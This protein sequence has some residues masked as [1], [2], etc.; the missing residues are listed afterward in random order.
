MV[1]RNNI[2]KLTNELYS[3]YKNVFVHKIQD[4]NDIKYALKP[5]VYGIH[6]Q[7][8]ETKKSTTWTDCKQYIYHLPSKQLLF[9]LHRFEES[10]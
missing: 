9:A 2:H 7:Y 3:I 6:K 4:K 10:D 5:L 1:Y 8:L